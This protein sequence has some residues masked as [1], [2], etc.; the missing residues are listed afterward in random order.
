MSATI[1]SAA[2]KLLATATS[3]AKVADLQ[4]D[5]IDPASKPNKGLTTDHGVYV[6]D[7]DNW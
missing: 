6:A 5:T 4:N 2:N 7:T 3:T 1:S